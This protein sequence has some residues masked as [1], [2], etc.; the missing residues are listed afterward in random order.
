MGLRARIVQGRVLPASIAE[1]FDVEEQI[2]PG[3]TVDTVLAE[4]EEF[5]FEGPDEAVHRCIVVPA[6]DAIHAGSDA[7]TLQQG[8][9]GMMGVLAAW[10]RVEDESLLWVASLEGSVRALNVKWPVMGSSRGPERRFWQRPTIERA[11]VHSLEGSRKYPHGQAYGCLGK[12][13]TQ[14]QGPEYV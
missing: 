6:A 13:L 12:G 2:G 1:R 4:I 14:R 10:V 5:A 9:I 3:L 11:H 8:L 7:V